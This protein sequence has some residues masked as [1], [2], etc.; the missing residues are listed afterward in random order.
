MKH[1]P[2][3]IVLLAAGLS[4]CGSNTRGAAPPQPTTYK[5]M[6]HDQRVEFMKTVVLPKTQALFVAFDPKFKDMDCETCHGDGATNGDFKMPNPKLHPLPNSEEAFMAWIGKE[7]AE[8]KWAGFMSQ[9]LEPLMG[10]LL[11]MPVFDPK[12]KTGEF[13]CKS[14]HELTSGPMPAAAPA[15]AA[16]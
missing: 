5:A 6:N 13:S 14:C 8:G 10:Q 7:P 4:A 15:T 9:Q 12:T 2:V 3:L 16:N 11:E 1:L